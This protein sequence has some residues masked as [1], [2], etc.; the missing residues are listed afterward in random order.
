ML[1]FIVEVTAGSSLD[2][3]VTLPRPEDDLILLGI[4]PSVDYSFIK[5]EGWSQVVV[6]SLYSE[7]LAAEIGGR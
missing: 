2:G 5:D 3:D 6:C 7:R 4:G 1:R